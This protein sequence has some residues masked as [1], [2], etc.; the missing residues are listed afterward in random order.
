MNPS[1]AKVISQ[2]Y[3]EKYLNQ[4]KQLMDQKAI[5]ME[6]ET[7][8]IVDVKMTTLETNLKIAQNDL[9]ESVFKK[10][11]IHERGET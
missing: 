3:L 1:G 10:A 7:R 5:E 11:S 9:V 2:S 4:H 8:K 6:R